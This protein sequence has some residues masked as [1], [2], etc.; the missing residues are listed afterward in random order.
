M[1]TDKQKQILQ[2][3]L[4]ADERYLKK[5]WGFRN[6]YTASEGHENYNEL[7]EMEKL[8]LVKSGKRIDQTVFWA[9]KQGALEIGFKPAQL[10]RTSLAA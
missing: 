8:G 6:H 3:M 7:L 10:R 1:V 2:H 9:T 4:G 5:E